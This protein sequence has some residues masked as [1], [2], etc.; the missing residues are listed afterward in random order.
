MLT[1]QTISFS[2]LGTLL[3]YK[4]AIERRYLVIGI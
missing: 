1:Y 2:L 3:D 4:K